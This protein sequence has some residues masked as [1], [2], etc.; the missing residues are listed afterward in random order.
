MKQIEINGMVYEFD[1]KLILKQEIRVGQNVQILK[2][3]YGDKYKLYPGVV[4]QIL[5]FESTPVVEIIYV[6]ADYSSCEVKKALVR[7]GSDEVQIISKPDTLKMIT[8]EHCED[9]LIREITKAETKLRDAK[10]NLEYFRKYFG[11]Y[12][13]DIKEK[14]GAENGSAE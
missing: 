10:A 4:T 8:K 9:L 13:G 14:E 7:E 1:E 5:P 2:K 11:M 12:W 3:D 6:E